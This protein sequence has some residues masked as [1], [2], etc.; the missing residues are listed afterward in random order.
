ML[1][2]LVSG[3]FGDET[4]EDGAFFLDRCIPGGG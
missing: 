4:D 2:V 3:V 1:A